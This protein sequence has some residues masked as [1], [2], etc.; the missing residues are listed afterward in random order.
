MSF[1]MRKRK[2]IGMW[3]SGEN[4]GGIGGGIKCTEEKIFSIKIQNKGNINFQSK[5]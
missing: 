3:W 2:G 1:L 4:L 5:P